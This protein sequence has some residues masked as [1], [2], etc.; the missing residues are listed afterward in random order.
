VGN[1]ELRLLRLEERRA[2]DA[3]G[4]ILRRARSAST[5]SLA[6]FIL[7]R[8]LAPEGERFEVMEERVWGYLDVPMEMAQLASKQGGWAEKL[9]D[10][11]AERRGILEHMYSRYP[12]ASRQHFG[13]EDAKG[14][15]KTHEKEEQ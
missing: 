8:E 15:N 14:V 4:G 9:G 5:D 13:E 6:Q 10:L 1:L 7:A 3:S 2:A 11:I 12:E